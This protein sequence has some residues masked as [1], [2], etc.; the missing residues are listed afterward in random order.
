MDLLT[1]EPRHI[2]RW[3]GGRE[4]ARAL[5]ALVLL[6]GL[7]G[8]FVAGA[9]AY[10]G[11][12]VSALK[13]AL[14]PASPEP[15]PACPVDAVDVP[16]LEILMGDKAYR[17][18]VAKRAEFLQGGLVMIHDSED[19]VEAYVRLGAN[20]A[21]A[22]AEVR[23][24]GNMVDRVRDPEKWSFRVDLDEPARILGMNEFNIAPPWAR[25]YMSEW[26]YMQAL[27]YE[28]LISSRYT[29]VRV[30]L[31][32]QDLGIYGLEEH[33]GQPLLENNR[34]EPAPLL[35]FEQDTLWQEWQAFTGDIVTSEGTGA[36]SLYAAEIRPYD[37]SAVAASA[38]TAQGAGE[39]GAAAL[40]K[41][42]VAAATLLDAFRLGELPAHAVFDVDLTARFLALTD[43]MGAWHTLNWN[44]M[45]F[46]YNPLTG[47]LEPV[48]LNG[49]NDYTGASI[50]KVGLLG[51]EIELYAFPRT[52]ELHARFFADEPLA[53]AYGRE[54]ERLSDP[55]W[56]DAFTVSVAAEARRS[57]ALL[58]LEVPEASCSVQVFYDNAAHI[59]KVLNS[60][61]KG[62]QAYFERYTPSDAAGG[63]S[64]T[65][66]VANMQKLA[67]EVVEL[68]YNGAAL[69]PLPGEQ[70]V[71]AGRRLAMQYRPITF[72]WPADVA[73]TPAAQAELT[74]VYHPVGTGAGNRHESAVFAWP[75]GRP[76]ELAKQ[77][78]A[79]DLADVAQYPFLQVDEAAR[80]IRLLPGE[81]TLTESVM[82]P[83]GYEVRCGPGTILRLREG[84]SLVSRSP[85]R[86]VGAETAPI[87]LD[88]GDS[89]GGLLVLQA[90]PSRF[91]QVVFNR[92]RAPSVNGASAWG[93]VRP[94]WG[95]ITLY[96]TPS[97]WDQCRI[98]GA[99]DQHALHVVDADTVLQDTLIQG[100]AA[101]GVCVERGSATLVNIVFENIGASALDARGATV[102]VTRMSAQGAGGWGVLAREGASVFASEL[103]IV[104]C[105]VGLAAADH[106]VLEVSGATLRDCGTALAAYQAHAEWGP[107]TLEV[108]GLTLA[109]NGRDALVQTDSQLLLEGTL[110][111]H[112]ERD[113]TGLLLGGAAR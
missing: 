104:G 49:Y 100:V 88:G 32:N 66:Q 42:F 52:R 63:P 19:F 95:A 79:Q 64:V 67:A 93:A 76:E 36:G 94:P 24:T 1:R 80:A 2:K 54:L 22:K 23:L 75:Y 73:W 91:E 62:M 10:R 110:Q 107:G 72:V 26:Y 86:W 27:R 50:A 53:R 70:T 12:V 37:S 108:G 85:L 47:L 92:L 58:A 29:F 14:L 105:A 68:R 20:Q 59:R 45:R 101:N 13:R 8:A 35:R 15:T 109:G 9:L 28:G 90:G 31:N 5:L 56:L 61:S 6:L 48:G 74:L 69:A 57:Y 3:P 65:L 96:Q 41:E 106:G 77:L 30:L 39:A 40:A 98:V 34:R 18:I 25:D 17:Q 87:V 33:P 51:E 60:E 97:E 4:G 46:Y 103:T 102:R 83:A 38:Q 99:Q 89:G 21:P 84:A 113:V 112:T 16:V 71:Y 82:L 11:G 78:Q 55:A 44:M 7:G 81:W 43:L 111:T